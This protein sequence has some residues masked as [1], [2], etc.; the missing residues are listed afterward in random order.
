[1]KM[2]MKMKRR[3]TLLL[4]IISVFTVISMCGCGKEEEKNVISVTG[5]EVKEGEEITVYIRATDKIPVAAYG[6]D[7]YYDS[8]ALTFKECEKTSDFEKAWSGMD[9]YNDKDE[10]DGKR[11]VI[12][13]GV[14]TNESETFYEGDLY[15]ITFTATGKKGTEAELTLKVSALEDLDQKDYLEE[16]TVKNGT[17]KIK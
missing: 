17:I 13:V 2:K 10:G 11:D 14:N 15:Y 16:Y 6:F 12:C 3:A 8:E 1:M 5:G 7:V 4:A 9:I